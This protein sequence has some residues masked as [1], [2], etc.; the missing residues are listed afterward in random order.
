MVKN[1]FL[2]MFVGCTPSSLL[3]SHNTTTGFMEPT[4]EPDDKPQNLTFICRNL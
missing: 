3:A 1:Y 4:R 2:E